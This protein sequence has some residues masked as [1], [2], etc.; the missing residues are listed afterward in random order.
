LVE[1]DISDN[2]FGAKLPEC[3]SNLT[4]LRVLNLGNNLF[5]GNF[6]SFTSNLT[7]LEYL[8]FYGNYMQGSFS[9]STLANHSNLQHLYISSKNSTGV[10]IETEKTK[11]FPK[12]QLRS[13]ILRNCILNKEQGSV[14]PT[15]LS[16]Q[17]NLVI[18]VLSSNNI[19]GSLPS[20]WLI[21]NLVF[22]DISN[23]N[24]SGL[25][26]K[27]IGIFLPSVTFLNFS[28]NSFEGNIPS[29]IGKMKNLEHLDFSYNH[30]SGELPKQLATDLRY[31]IL[32]N[33]S[34]CG[35]FPKFVHMEV[36]FL[37]NNNFSGTLEDVLGNNTQ[38]FM[39]SISNNSFSGTI[40]TSIGMFYRIA[41]LLMSENLLEGEIPIEISNMSRLEM[42][43]L[44]QN[45]LNG[46][47]P[48]LTSGSLRFLYLQQNDLSGSMPSEFS[49]GSPLQLLDLREN[50]FS[51][52]IPN[53]M[54]KLSQLRVLLLGGNNFEGEIPIQLCQL[55]KID[56]M[57]LSQNKLNASIPSCFQNMSFGMRQY[58][59]DDRTFEFSIN[60]GGP[61]DLSNI[62]I[63]DFIRNPNSFFNTS[64][65]IESPLTEYSEDE[66]L[67]FE[68][69]FRTKY[70]YYFYKGKVLEKMTG[71]DLS[72][73]KLTGTIP[74]QI[75]DL[76]QIRALNLSHNHLS[77]PIPITFFNL[78]QI[79]SLDLSYNNLSGEIPSQLTKLN[80]LSTFNVSY[81]NLS[82]TPPSTGQFG[83]FDEDNYRGNPGL[84]GPL[85]NRKCEHVEPSP[86]SQS[87]DNE[88]EEM[89]VDMITFYWSFTASYITILLAFIT[90]LCINPRWRMA[91]FYY[92]SKFMR[93]FFPT[94]PLY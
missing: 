28:W 22:L 10:H 42:M 6:P 43:D 12:F 17:Y 72:C 64:L 31:L 60:L 71:L 48:K 82:G 70:N 9:L 5:S 55:K 90:V 20:N 14:I 74:S 85:L 53:W 94:F 23:N 68:V 59:H 58:V 88:G 91:W 93:R 21:P 11:W 56:I 38:L 47:I 89:S 54:D 3:F 45:K 35:N 26:P 61:F 40:P 77:G 84:C 51:G 80:F 13:L 75:G 66:Y 44:S 27:D 24:L 83:C 65:R 34:L 81:N 86:S 1:L 30:F 79:E 8:S 37:N 15:F 36:L 69:E 57:D 92:I 76:Q 73:N 62:I 33:N 49:E 67:Q 25:L 87:N 50:K 63:E 46:S 19:T 4:N 32:S 78:T 39:L 7:S 29:S 18:L 2:M 16:Y 52:K 41:V